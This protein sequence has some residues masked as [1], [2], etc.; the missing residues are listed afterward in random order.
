MF[1]LKANGCKP[2][3]AVRVVL[4]A[5]L[6]LLLPASTLA[7]TTVGTGSIIGTIVDPTGAVVEGARITI[8]NVDTGQAI[9]LTRIP[10]GLTTLEP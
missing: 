10:Q 1:L 4:V 9:N 2:S 5:S 8:T 6:L 7:Q 3:H